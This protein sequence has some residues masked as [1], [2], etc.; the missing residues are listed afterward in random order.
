MTRKLLLVCG[1]LSSLL[2]VATVVLAPLGWQG[3]SSRAQTVSELIAVDAPTRPLVA[4]LFVLYALLVYAFGVGVW[5]S[6]AQK[7]AV[8]LVAVGLIGKEVLGLVVTLFFPMHLREVLAVGGGTLSDSLHGTLTLVG[9][10]FMLLA[11]G[12]AAFAFGGWFRL[13]SIGTL[14][15][16]VLGGVLSGRDIPLMEANLPTPWMGV[17]ERVNIFAFMLWVVVL[18]SLLLRAQV[19]GRSHPGQIAAAARH[20]T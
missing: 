5:Q 20:A 12:S 10:L 13:Y 3:Y 15:L 7:F 17:W 4:A 1:I 19:E 14:L 16:L 6:A 18:A 9:V 8:R 11:L 2:Y